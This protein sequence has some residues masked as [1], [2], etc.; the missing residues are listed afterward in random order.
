VADARD[1]SRILDLERRVRQDPASL[2]FAP[3]AEEYRR[4]GR[5][6]DAIRTCRAGLE[7]HPGYV[8]ARATL[9]RALLDQGDLDAALAELTT[10]LEAA[11][12]HLGALRGVADLLRRRGELA[13]A[14]DKY[15]L[16]LALA[17]DDE[18]LAA[19]VAE[20][21]SLLA[22]DTGTF[23]RDAAVTRRQIAVLE[24]WLARILADRAARHPRA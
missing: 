7:V 10:V 14:L 3:L 19:R 20:L 22:A 21:E 1:T 9:G 11:P 2:A 18:E 4:A 5:L 12:E 15:R 16:A 13:A 23:R 6:A 24:T 17:R 8:S